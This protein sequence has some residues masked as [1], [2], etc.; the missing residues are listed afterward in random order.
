MKPLVLAA[1]VAISIFFAFPARGQLVP[2]G[3][4][5]DPETKYLMKDGTYL[6]FRQVNLSMGE[7]GFEVTISSNIK[8]KG[9]PTLE[10]R[11]DKPRGKKIGTLKIPDTADTTFNIKLTGQLRHAM[12]VHDLFLVAKGSGEFQ[13]FG[14]AFIRNY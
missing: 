2:A 9:S 12:G 6:G 5:R 14:F 8:G 3:E 10:F 13:I 11:I 4:P 1:I 7:I